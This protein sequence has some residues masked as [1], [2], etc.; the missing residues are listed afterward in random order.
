[1]VRGDAEVFLA[2]G[3]QRHRLRC[4]PIPETDAVASSLRLELAKLHLL[5]P[6]SRLP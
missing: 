4:V 6:P 3:T 1:M 2:C 5:A